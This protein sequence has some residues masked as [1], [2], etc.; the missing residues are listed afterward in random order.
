MLTTVASAAIA[1][2]PAAAPAASRGC[3]PRRRSCRPAAAPAPAAPDLAARVADL[4]AYMTNSAPKVM[5]TVPGP[6]H[7]G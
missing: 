3:C 5:T 7:N 4:E 2:S 1:Q 6:G